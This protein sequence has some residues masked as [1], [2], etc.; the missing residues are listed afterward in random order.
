M[1]LLGLDSHKTTNLI[2]RGLRIFSSQAPL[3]EYYLL[4][5]II[6]DT[7]YWDDPFF[8]KEPETFKKIS[9]Q[10]AIRGFPTGYDSESRK[11]CQHTLKRAFAQR[12]NVIHLIPN[13]M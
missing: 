4:F 6:A 3:F 13:I 1:N 12:G 9:L 7:H 10:S 2:I 8:F 11:W 5:I